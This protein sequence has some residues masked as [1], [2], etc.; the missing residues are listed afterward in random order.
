MKKFFLFLFVF[1]LCL[2]ASAQFAPEDFRPLNINVEKCQWVWTNCVPEETVPLKGKV[3]VAKEGEPYDLK[4]RVARKGES[5]DMTV[6]VVKKYP[7]ECGMWMWVK[8]RK[9]ASFVVKF[10]TKVGEENLIVVFEDG[11]KNRQNT[12]L[13]CVD[14]S[15]G[16]PEPCK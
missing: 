3:Y 1:S 7:N 4:I 13:P 9:D 12:D 11:E 8:N 16:H 10:V 6:G 14:Y 2:T 15:S 5:S